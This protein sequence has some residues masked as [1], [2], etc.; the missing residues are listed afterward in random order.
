MPNKN[1]KVKVDIDN[2]TNNVL[3]VE[4]VKQNGNTENK[5]QQKRAPFAVVEAY[6]SIRTNLTFMLPHT[7]KGNVVTITS[8]NASEG[9]STTAVNLSV[10]FSQLEDK[11]LIIDADMRRSS[12]HKKL[13]LKNDTGLS[14]VLAGICDFDSAVCKLNEGFHVL[15]SGQIPP[16]P[17]ELLGSKAFEELINLVKERYDYVIIDTPP[18][19]V[20]SDALVVAPHT[21]GI[22]MVVRDGFTP[23]Y[24]IK[25]ALAVASF[26]NVKILGAI[27]NGANPRSGGK[28]I[29]RKYSYR[30]KYYRYGY[31]YSRKYGYGGKYGY[32][33]KYGYGYSS[34]APSVPEKPKK[35]KK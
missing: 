8:A 12:V 6:K 19:N 33:S 18:V 29:Y 15:T 10:A 22:V 25:R 23:N 30:S 34:D 24:T 5:P 31:G 14:N 11:I 28:Y 35:G 3:T 9:K 32:G 4:D 2:A 7:D 1:K 26:A 21:D 16:N 13:K 17:S 27:M 20:V